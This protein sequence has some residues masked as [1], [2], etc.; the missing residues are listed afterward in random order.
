MNVHKHARMTIHGRVLLV[1]RI[2][3]EHWRVADAAEAAGVSV[4]TADKWLARFRVGGE[5]MLH[6]RSSQP[7]RKPRKPRLHDCSHER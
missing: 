1:N 4:H 3:Q 2:L 5:R 7:A 6:D